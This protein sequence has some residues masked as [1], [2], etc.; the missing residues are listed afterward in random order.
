[1]KLTLATVR[2]VL[3]RSTLFAVL[4][5]ALTGGDPDSW[6]VGSVSVTLATCA[7]LVLLPPRPTR[8][9]GLGL[10]RFVVFFLTES[11]RGG[12]QVAAFALRP[13]MGLKP[14]FHEVSLRLPEGF[15]RILLVN[16]LNLLPGTLSAELDDDRLCLHV[17][18]D[19]MPTEI[20][21]R[22]AEARIAH[23]LGL[24][25]ESA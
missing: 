23:M 11:L 5:W 10:V 4:W 7:S 8:V 24:A 22:A 20:E 3:W 21:V 17:L 9:S 1:M 14:A 6:G 13:R 12:V 2:T 19:T 16:T 25:F 18:D 15:G